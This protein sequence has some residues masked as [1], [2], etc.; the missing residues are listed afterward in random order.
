MLAAA[1]TAMVNNTGSQRRV[2]LT[3]DAQAKE[4][5]SAIKAT[6]EQSSDFRLRP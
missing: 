3:Q 6:G 4:N 5:P 1:A 2:D